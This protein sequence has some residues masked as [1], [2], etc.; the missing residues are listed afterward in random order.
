MLTG[1]QIREAR[2]LLNWERTIISRRVGFP[3]SVIDC[4]E[5]C[6]GEANITVAQE[7]KIKSVFEK[8][9]VEFTVEPPGARLRTGAP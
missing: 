5:A 6:D 1:P 4:A 9:G 2:R 3:V 8:A 7:I